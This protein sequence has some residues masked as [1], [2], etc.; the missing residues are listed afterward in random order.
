M[1]PAAPKQDIAP[2][3]TRFHPLVSW[4]LSRLST[5]SLTVLPSILSTQASELDLDHIDQTSFWGCLYLNLCISQTPLI[6]QVLVPQLSQQCCSSW[7]KLQKSW[8]FS[9][10]LSVIYTGLHHSLKIPLRSFRTKGSIKNVY[11]LYI[12]STIKA[13]SPQI[14]RALA[15]LN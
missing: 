3:F 5:D 12:Q 6:L 14:A 9:T 11:S 2:S 15:C 13:L 8:Y 1:F 7:F 4:K 10:S